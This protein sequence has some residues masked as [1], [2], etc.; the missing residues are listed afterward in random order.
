MLKSG[1]HTLKH[2]LLSLYNTM[3]QPNTPPPKSWQHTLIKVLYKSG[4]HRLPQNYRPIATIPIL[5]KLFSRLLYNRLEPILDPQ[6]SPEQAGFRRS[7]STTDHL[8]TITILQEI[9]DEWQLPLWIAAVDF[10]K[11]FD[12]VTHAALWKALQEQGVDEPHIRLLEKLYMTQTATVKTDCTSRTFNIERG[13]KQ[14]DPLSS[15]LFN[16]VTESLLRTTKQKWQIKRWGIRTHPNDN[17]TITNLRFAD[18]ILLLSTSLPHITAML[19]DLSIEAGKI[20]L[21]LH[22]DKTKILHNRIHNTLR[23]NALSQVRAN[24][25]DIEILPATGST[26]YL[27]R[28][29][30]FT[31]PHRTELENRISYAWKRFFM[32]KQ[33]LTGRHYSL[34]DRLRLFHGAIT[35]TILYGSEAWTLTVDLENRLKRIQRQ[36]LRM[37]LHA[38]RRRIN[39]EDRSPST[40]PQTQTTSQQPTNTTSDANQHTPHTDDDIS[41]DDVDSTCS[42]TPVRPPQDDDDTTEAEPWADWI[43]RCTHEV[44]ERMNKLHLDDWV[45]IQRRRKWRWAMKL[46]TDPTDNLTTRALQWDPMLDAQL[47]NRR[48]RGRPKT[49]WSDDICKYIRQMQRAMATTTT[50]N[51]HDNHDNTD[52]TNFPDY[53]MN[54]DGIDDVNEQQLYDNNLWL[55]LATDKSIW[56]ALEDGYVALSSRN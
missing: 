50:D 30:S 8:F 41:D 11:A 1:G 34:S 52:D 47:N 55:E 29:L 10:K 45:S 14:G 51:N 28:K 48:R 7:R 15:L 19:T 39:S 37:I 25:M 6:Q 49:R 46:A 35:P 3:L 43:R 36:M 13:V 21:Q 20:G 23:T 18:D 56:E 54:P 5:Y 12:S 24:G 22:P 32:L 38:P 9:A 42:T 26:K 4:D 33:E 31:D 27:G 53:E 44:E 16:S 40:Q 2:A 17:T